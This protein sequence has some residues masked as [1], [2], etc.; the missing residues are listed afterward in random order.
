MAKE[1]NKERRIEEKQDGVNLLPRQRTCSLSDGISP[2][3]R[4]GPS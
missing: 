4:V 1:K 2:F 3:M